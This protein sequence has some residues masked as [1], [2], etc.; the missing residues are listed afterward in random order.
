MDPGSSV[1]MSRL[2]GREE[3]EGLDKAVNRER[4]LREVGEMRLVRNDI[5]L[6]SGLG[7]PRTIHPFTQMSW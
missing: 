1:L 7:T 2:S 5:Q 3:N 4:H 6:P